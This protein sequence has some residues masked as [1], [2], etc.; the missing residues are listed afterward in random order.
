MGV[1]LQERVGRVFLELKVQDELAE[2]E[3]VEEVV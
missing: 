1:A 3:V 2:V